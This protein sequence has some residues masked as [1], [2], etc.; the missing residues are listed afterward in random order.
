MEQKM[1]VEMGPMTAE[2]LDAEIN[3]LFD[4]SVD[5]SNKHPYDPLGRTES[6]L[7]NIAESI[8]KDAMDKASQAGLP[9]DT[10]INFCARFLG[11]L[12]TNGIVDSPIQSIQQ[13]EETIKED[14]I[15]T[16]MEI[17]DA[18]VRAGI[19]D[20]LDCMKESF[21]VLEDSNEANTTPI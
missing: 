10:V 14:G 21:S 11:I 9:Y 17:I 12:Y 16:F 4:E 13:I 8:F 20:T 3:A 5:V 2:E 1:K 15:K 19:D 18:S 6:E 7:F